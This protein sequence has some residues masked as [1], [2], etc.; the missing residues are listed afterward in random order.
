METDGRGE[1][2]TPFQP[3]G[4]FD[5]NKTYL[6]LQANNVPDI[7]IRLQPNLIYSAD[8]HRTQYPGRPVNICG[9]T[10]ITTTKTLFTTTGTRLTHASLHGS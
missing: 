10:D 1:N 2:P 8:Y 6:C 7:F 4:T 5:S 9:Q 3:K